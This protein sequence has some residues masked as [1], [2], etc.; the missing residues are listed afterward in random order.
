MRIHKLW[1]LTVA[2]ALVLG[3]FGTVAAEST[4]VPVEEEVD[5]V[6][7]PDVSGELAESTALLHE[8]GIME[9]WDDLFWP[10]EPF[11]REQLAAVVV[12]ML[13]SEGRAALLAGEEAYMY[14]DAPAAGWWSSPYLTVAFERG[15]M[16]GWFDTPGRVFAPKGNVTFQETVTITLRALG[17][18]TEEMKGNWPQAYLDEALEIGL[19][20]EEEFERGAELATRGEIARIICA[21]M[22]EV[23]QQETGMFLADIDRDFVIG[24]DWPTPGGTR[25]IIY[26]TNNTDEDIVLSGATIGED[27]CLEIPQEW[28]INTTIPANTTAEL[29]LIRPGRP[30]GCHSFYGEAIYHVIVDL[31]VDGEMAYSTELHHQGVGYLCPDESSVT[32]TDNEDGTAT[33]VATLRDEAARPVT[34]LADENAFRLVRASDYA[35]FDREVDP[36]LEV[37]GEMISIEETAPGEYT[38]IWAYDEDGEYEVVMEIPMG[39]IEDLTLTITGN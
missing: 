34:W 18:E 26:A 27:G 7:F 3:T 32:L 1:C 38:I 30:G 29:F 37:L 14:A 24:S 21:G 22:T 13:A 2:L 15:L 16:V 33:I 9:G 10:D 25:I 5:W 8:L 23:A 31:Y 11:T 4:I 36:P 17:Y 35:T 39:A 28:I 20:T 19:I 6:L 12:R